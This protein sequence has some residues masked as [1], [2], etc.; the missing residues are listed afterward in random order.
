[1]DS[2]LSVKNNTRNGFFQVVFC[3]N[4]APSHLRRTAGGAILEN[5]EG[6]GVFVAPQLW[7][8]REPQMAKRRI[9]WGKI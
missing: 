6:K 8:G 7:R 1:M 3:E 5:A 2:H 9:F 4:D